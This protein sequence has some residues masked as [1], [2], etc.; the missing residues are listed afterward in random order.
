MTRID[1]RPRPAPMPDE[2]RGWNWGAFLLNWIWGI[3]N[4]TFIALLCCVPF[5]GIVMPFVLG[6]RG[7]E[8]AWR[9]GRWDDIAQFR[10]VQ[11]RWAIWGVVIVGAVVCLFGAVVGGLV[12]VLKTS[13]AYR[14]GVERLGQSRAA[15]DLLGSPIATGFPMGS[16]TTN[17]S[18]GEAV[19]DFSATGPG[20]SGRIVL[21]A[22][23]T[24]G[25]WALTV[26]RLRTDGSTEAIDLLTEDHAA[27]RPGP[28]AVARLG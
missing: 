4:N 1:D 15:T 14:L 17:G 28:R 5:V 27:V 13:D 25:T 19:L 26:L 11:R 20:A 22:I 24:D 18:S 3:G 10:R 7:N 6:A 9:N 12:Y 21:Q 8:W 16:I 2:L 23:E